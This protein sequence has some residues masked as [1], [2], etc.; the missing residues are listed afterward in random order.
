MAQ[1]LRAW[2]KM[3]AVGSGGHIPFA[4]WT[5]HFMGDVG[6]LTVQGAGQG[7]SLA[8]SEGRTAPTSVLS[9][10]TRLFSAIGQLVP[11]PFVLFS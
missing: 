8:K 3:E 1:V 11:L 7:P 4:L 6:A 5:P 9:P 2:F 10:N